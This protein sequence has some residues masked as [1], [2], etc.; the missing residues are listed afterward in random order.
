VIFADERCCERALRAE[1]HPAKRGAIEDGSVN[2]SLKVFVVWENTVHMFHI[3]LD[4]A[5]PILPRS[6]GR[7]VT[8]VPHQ[9]LLRE[10]RGNQWRTAENFS[11]L[12]ECGSVSH[13]MSVV[14]ASHKLR[15][16]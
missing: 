12:T 7:N 15:C 2:I 6:G 4:S 8:E 11:R 16:Y 14:T 9:E 1:S 5:C 13:G 3:V 10:I